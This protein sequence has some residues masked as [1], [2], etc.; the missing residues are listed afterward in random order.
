MYHTVVTSTYKEI[1][2]MIL[3]TLDYRKNKHDSG[4]H[5]EWNYFDNIV[6]A[7]TYFDEDIKMTVV[8]CT[9]RDGNIVTFAIPNVAY[10]MSDTGK[11]I[12]KIMAANV[13][14][15][16]DTEEAVYNTLLDAAN[17]AMEE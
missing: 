16:G 11:T 14:E 2:S 4:V 15:L 9:F 1:D 13:E 10:L 8:R 6:N 7:S 3:K 12:E 5:E 17:A